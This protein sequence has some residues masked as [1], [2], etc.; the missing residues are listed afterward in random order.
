VERQLLE[1][2]VLVGQLVEWLEL[3]RLELERQQLVRW[4]M[5]RSKLGLIACGRGR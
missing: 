2:L 4:S 5:A 1:R 3:E